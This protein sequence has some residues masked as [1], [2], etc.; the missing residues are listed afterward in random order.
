M[1]YLGILI[2]IVLVS[3]CVTATK[4]P[5]GFVL[6]NEQRFA[7]CY[8]SNIDKYIGNCVVNSLENETTLNEWLVLL[9][10]ENDW[11]TLKE[12]NQTINEKNASG[13]LTTEVANL[14]FERSYNL[15]RDEFNS[16]QQNLYATDEAERIKKAQMWMAVGEALQTSNNTL[17]NRVGTTPMPN[18]TIQP[19]KLTNLYRKSSEYIEGTQ[20]VCVYKSSFNKKTEF[21][22]LNNRYQMCPMTISV[23]IN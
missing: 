1:K 9:D 6:S 3:S 18:T 17:N 5:D 21:K 22:V 2:C 11:E 20:K 16:K 8:A 14:M 4:Y 15:T 23:P 12:A 7:S 19:S 13:E 10:V